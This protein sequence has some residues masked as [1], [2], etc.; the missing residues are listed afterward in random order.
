MSR[1]D[2]LYANPDKIRA[3]ARDLKIAEFRERH[4]AQRHSV[5]ARRPTPAWDRPRMSAAVRR[6]ISE[7]LED[8][9]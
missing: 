3:E 9:A 7:A 6:E 1:P 4:N 5:A 8:V 2:P